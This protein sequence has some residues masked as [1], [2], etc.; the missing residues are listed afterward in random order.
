MMVPVETINQSVEQF[1][2]RL[3]ETDQGVKIICEWDKVRF[4]IP[5]K[6]M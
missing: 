1:T 4:V 2:I 3:G 5:V 6:A